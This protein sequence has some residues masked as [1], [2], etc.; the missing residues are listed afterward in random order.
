MS[1]CLVNSSTH[2]EP[3]FFVYA[4]TALCLLYAP[5]SSMLH[6]GG[7]C[8]RACPVPALVGMEGIA[9]SVTCSSILWVLKLFEQHKQILL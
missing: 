1:G 8:G 9:L 6:D 5:V 4:Y 7:G 3:P 2:T